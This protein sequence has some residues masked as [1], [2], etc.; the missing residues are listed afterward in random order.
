MNKMDNVVL[1]KV[2]DKV[3]ESLNP[4]SEIV[5][6]NYLELMNSP[7][8]DEL[9]ITKEIWD[10]LTVEV[11][12]ELIIAKYKETKEEYSNTPLNGAYEDIYITL[13]EEC[14]SGAELEYEIEKFANDTIF[15]QYSEK[16]LR[17]MTIPISRG[18]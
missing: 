2:T 13:E 12:K 3:R 18:E 9:Y 15:I 7:G 5:V 14:V 6:M 11:K 4:Y 10:R 1:I 16:E 17:E 8:D